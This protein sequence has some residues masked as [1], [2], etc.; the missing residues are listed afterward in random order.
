MKPNKLQKKR[1]PNLDDETINKVVEILDGWSFQKITWELFVEQ[2]FLRLRVRYTRQ[3][4]NNYTRIKDAFSICKSNTREFNQ[5]IMQVET[6][7]QRRIH[8]LEAEVER[9]TRENNALLEQFNRWVYNGYLKTMDEKMRD[10]MNEPLP[11][12][13]RESSRNI[14]NIDAERKRK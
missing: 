8:R 6:P 5:K 11:S 14:S 12:M 2:I 7:D 4:L 13:Q 3:A 10:F 9:L 1:A